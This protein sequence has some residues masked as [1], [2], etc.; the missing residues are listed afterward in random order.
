MPSDTYSSRLGLRLQ[1]TGNND[2][3][4][5]D[6]LN[7]DTIQLI[8]DAI[9]AR[10]AVS[11]SGGS[12]SLSET[13]A[14]SMILN[15]SGTLTSAQAIVVPNVSKM[16]LVRNATAGDYALSLKTASGTAVAVPQGS[17]C[18][19]FCDG[20]DTIYVS[21]GNDTSNGLRFASGQVSLYVAGEE[22]FR[23][24]SAA[25]PNA[26]QAFD[27]LTIRQSL[28]GATAICVNAQASSALY[29]ST[30]I[31]MNCARAASTAFYHWMAT[32]A[33]AAN[34]SGYF[35][36]DGTMAIDGSYASGGAD[37]AEYFEWADGN[38]NNEDRVG[39]SVT[40]VKGNKIARATSSKNL[41]GIVSANPTIVGD[42]NQLQW[43]DKFLR[44]DFGRVLTEPVNV[45]SWTERWY[46]DRVEQYA[47]EVTT[48]MTNDEQK[49]V[50]M[51]RM[52]PKEPKVETVTRSRTVKVPREKHY[53]YAE[54]DLPAGI[55]PPPD[56]SWK[57]SAYPILNPDY[58]PAA[59]YVPREERP[60]WSPVGMMGKLRM[61]KGEKVDLRWRKL[62]DISDAVE[63][64]LVR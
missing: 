9:A 33:N 10:S 20:A 40:L 62:R 58:D 17:W 60:E 51:K 22:L 54:R 5:G 59:R 44:D 26:I 30:Q 38:P 46:E 43:G 36:G 34:I 28:T 47:E 11:V 1:G 3:T 12:T 39:W 25:A 48:G 4:W 42:S 24:A 55:I 8:E 52:L 14:R 13:Q 15:F 49:L 29:D 32:T 53:E 16:W 63:E 37:Y 18:V 61:R 64:W 35:R 41:L 27:T 57:V 6:L 7:T 56:A 2:N 21:V 23:I 50:E 45:A 19:A 31:F